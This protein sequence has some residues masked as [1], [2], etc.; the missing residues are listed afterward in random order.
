MKISQVK[1]CNS[2]E[3][4]DFSIPSLLTIFF[5]PVYLV[6]DKSLHSLV[7]LDDSKFCDLT[8]DTIFITI[9]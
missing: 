4:R 1:S 6:I 3:Y 7:N 9:Q 8:T 5:V 2:A